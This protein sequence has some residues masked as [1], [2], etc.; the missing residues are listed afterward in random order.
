VA[1]GEDQHPGGA[2]TGFQ[3]GEHGDAVHAGQLE[4]EQDDVGGL[5]GG[6]RERGVAVAGD[7]MPAAHQ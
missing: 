4:V 3:R 6:E 5:F 2:V 7:L 1:A